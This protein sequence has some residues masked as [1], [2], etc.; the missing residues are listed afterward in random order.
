MGDDSLVLC[1]EKYAD[2]EKERKLRIPIN[3]QTLEMKAS[4][5]QLKLVSTS[6]Y[7]YNN[8]NNNKLQT[9]TC[10]LGQDFRISSISWTKPG[11]V[12]FLYPL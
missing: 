11:C 2:I 4:E 3:F 6:A 5:Q 9:Y 1:G 10:S 8:Y 12:D 7:N